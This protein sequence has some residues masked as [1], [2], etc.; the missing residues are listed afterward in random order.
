MH[1]REMEWSPLR[2]FHTNSQGVRM[3]S[4][5]QG[6]WGCNICGRTILH[7]EVQAYASVDATTVSGPSDGARTLVVDF[8]FG[9]STWVCLP[10]CTLSAVDACADVSSA[11]ASAMGPSDTS[12]VS[13]NA[14]ALPS[15]CERPRSNTFFSAA[16]PVQ[17]HDATNFFVYCPILLHAAGLLSPEVVSSWSSAIPWFDPLCLHISQQLHDARH[18]AQAYAELREL[19]RNCNHDEARAVS[20]LQRLV[21]RCPPGARIGVRLFLSLVVDQS[22]HV[23]NLLQDLTMQVFA[24][25]PLASE[26][27]LAV[28]VFRDQGRW[29]GNLQHLPADPAPVDR[30]VTHNPVTDVAPVSACPATLANHGHATMPTRAHEHTHDAI[31]ISSLTPPLSCSRR[32]Y[33]NTLANDVEVLRAAHDADAEFAMPAYRIVHS[34]FIAAR[35]VGLPCVLR[36]FDHPRGVRLVV[37]PV[38]V[39]RVNHRNYKLLPMP[40][41]R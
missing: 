3:Q 33:I 7:T 12:P 5:W 9:S 4:G 32:I 25:L 19:S 14:P 36:A 31:S 18:F 40:A 13:A 28:T 16:P 15:A 30:P 1:A 2:T 39:L 29:P 41:L 38:S 17:N 26:L 11:A 22:G 23:P 8:A 35:T 34:T 21:G 24:G 20:E 27:D 6:E 37:M 10:G